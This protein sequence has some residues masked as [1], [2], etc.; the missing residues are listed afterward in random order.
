MNQQVDPCR[1]NT[2]LNSSE[3]LSFLMNDRSYLML[4][5]FIEKANN[6]FARKKFHMNIRH[7]EQIDG[8]DLDANN[9]TIE[10]LNYTSPVLQYKFVPYKEMTRIHP[11]GIKLYK[12]STSIDLTPVRYVPSTKEQQTQMDDVYIQLTGAPFYSDDFS[13]E[14]FQLSLLYDTLTEDEIRDIATRMY[15]LPV[16]EGT[17]FTLHNN[18]GL[19]DSYVD[20]DSLFK[21]Y[22]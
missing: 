5:R 2:L 11:G 17:E 18:I 14:L 13:D 9:H 20:F 10:V 22:S 8:I 16:L 7:Y 1:T 3:V 12:E 21:G 15:N 6:F 4:Y 19:L